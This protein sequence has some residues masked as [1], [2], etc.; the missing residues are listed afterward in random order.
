MEL[1]MIELATGNQAGTV[2]VSDA[3]FGVDFNETL[4]H[5]VVVAYMAGAR[6]GTK[7]QKTRSEVRGGGIKPWRQKGTGRA[8]AGT[9]RSPLW[10]GGGR[11]FP[12]HNRDFSQKVNKKMYRGAM[13]SILS[14]LNRNGRLIVVDD[15]KVEAP[16]TREFK[17]KLAQLGVNDALIVTEAFDEYLYLSSRNLYQADVCDVASIDPLSLVGFKNVV[18]T[19]G[20]VKQ[21]EE[22]YA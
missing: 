22:K 8:R 4:V 19:Q 2:G 7:K 5:Q 11:A 15:F 9:I 6:S 16:K 13:K 3:V 21:L 10:V 18:M 20:A 14:E 1:K 17:A 12:G